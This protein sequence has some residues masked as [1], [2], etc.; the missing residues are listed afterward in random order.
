MSTEDRVQTVL[1]VPAKVRAKFK[2]MAEADGRTMAGLF[3]HL[4][5]EEYMRRR[6]KSSAHR[7]VPLSAPRS[8]SP[9]DT[10]QEV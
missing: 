5:N 9:E 4:V 2:K 6:A 1:K 3:T 10:Q 8:T 7:R